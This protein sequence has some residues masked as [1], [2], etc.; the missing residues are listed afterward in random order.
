MRGKTWRV[1]TAASACVVLGAALSGCGGESGDS[2]TVTLKFLNY[3][4]WVGATE[5]ADFESANPGIK[6]EQY[7]LPDGG[8]SALAAQLAKDKGV[9]DLVAVGNATAA[10][11]DAGNLLAD[12]DPATVPNLENMPPQY[13]DEFPWGIPTDLGKVGI[14]YDK[15]KVPNPPTSWKELFD[16]AAQWTG[17][18]VLPDY[19]LDVQAI[20]LLSLGYD[21]NTTDSGE[22]EQAEAKIKEIKPHLLAFQRTGQAKSVVDGSALIAVGYDYAFAGA[23][24]PKLGWV[25]PKEGT[26]GYIEGVALLPGSTHTAEALKFLDFRLE[27]QTYG[28]FINNTGASYLM[29]SA[30]QYI[31]PKILENPALQQNTASPFM[32]EKFLS[33]EDTEARA[34]MWNRIKAS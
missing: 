26:P 34:K 7:A 25:S 31:E 33:A 16:N 17:K 4:D 28:G 24:D 12:F 29:P 22:L 13:V 1:L 11:L 8:S 5:I 10:R 18:I 15:E 3:G 2:D 9:Y 20:A 27:P 19:D 32:A 21:I 6:I 23:D 14:I 30:E